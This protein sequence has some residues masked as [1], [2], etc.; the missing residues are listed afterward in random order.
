MPKSFLASSVF[1]ASDDMTGIVRETKAGRN[2]RILR[3]C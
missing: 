1:S 2:R 3:V